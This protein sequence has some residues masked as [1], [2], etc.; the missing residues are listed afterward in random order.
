[1]E[2]KAVPIE[3]SGL[4]LDQT[5]TQDAMGTMVLLAFEAMT[6]GRV[7]KK[8][9]GGEADVR[10]TITSVLLAGKTTS[11]GGTQSV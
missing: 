8:K 10:T 5:L 2:G 9:P 11:G 4:H 6:V 3:E 7:R 1:M